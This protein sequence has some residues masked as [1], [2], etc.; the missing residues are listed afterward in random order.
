MMHQSRFSIPGILSLIIIFSGQYLCH[1][2]AWIRRWGQLCLSYFRM[3]VSFLPIS[4]HHSKMVTHILS[5]K[6]TVEQMNI[7]LIRNSGPLEAW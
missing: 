2:K 5:G 7:A 6:L 3:G 1:V 4:L